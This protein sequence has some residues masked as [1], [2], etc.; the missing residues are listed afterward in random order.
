MS[1]PD[2]QR[3]NGDLREAFAAGHYAGAKGMAD[4][5]RKVDPDHPLVAVVEAMLPKHP[6]ML[7]DHNLDLDRQI[8]VAGMGEI[9]EM[10][11]EPYRGPAKWP[12]RAP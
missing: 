12:K 9:P 2:A 11:P 1:D 10:P 3:V 5:L 4:R 6:Y 8:A 7:M